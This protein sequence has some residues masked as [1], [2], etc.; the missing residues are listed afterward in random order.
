MSLLSNFHHDRSTKL[1]MDG[2]MRLFGSPGE[3][4][5]QVQSG[6]VTDEVITS[7]GY[8]AHLSNFGA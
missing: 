2:R 6:V 3:D 1:T 4:E 8:M 5:R 7:S